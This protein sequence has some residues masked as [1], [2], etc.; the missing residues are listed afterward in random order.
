LQTIA[1]LSSRLQ[2]VT[3]MS[4]D[5]THSISSADRRRAS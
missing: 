1:G 4:D 2:L 3:G 5:A